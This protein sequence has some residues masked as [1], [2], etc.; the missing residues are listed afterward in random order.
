MWKAIVQ[1]ARA[2]VHL[3]RSVAMVFAMCLFVCVVCVTVAGSLIVV[4]VWL[5]PETV[6]LIRRIAG[7]KRHLVAM[8]TGQEIPQAY[9]PITGRL[10]QRLRTALRDPGTRSDLLWMAAFYLYGWMGLLTLALW[11]LGLVADGVWCGLLRRRPVVLPLISRLADL[12]AAWS[13]SLL[14]PFPQA[15]LAARVDELTQTRAGA[16][17]AHAAELRRIER[18]LHDGTQ[19]HLVSLSMR[20]G[21]ARRAY[22][23]APETARKL[24]DEA[25]EQAQ[26]ALAELRHVVRNIHPPILSDRGLAG[27]VRALA[28]GSGLDVTV[29]TDGLADDGPR[30]PA[31]VEAAA[32][33]AVAE[34][35]TNAAK[36]SG[37][38]RASVRLERTRTGLRVTVR[39]EG[40]GGADETSG[41]GL[42]GI[43]R[44]VAA[45]DG[46]VTVTSPE[47]GPT[48]VAV[49]LPCVW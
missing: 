23:S 8:W 10:R 33:F 16:V 45:L 15:L 9:Q 22:D 1:A 37:S 31:A 19:A 2:T 42:L 7:A 17:A 27:A 32:Y 20:L 5:I 38:S 40:E 12:E 30:A 13:A 47:G 49:E 44:R 41:S 28:A 43:R 3:G 24:L 46:T 48:V 34:A 21:L 18:D 6:L 4:G 25:Q 36:H 39:D 26:Q 14:K 11:P 29:D 35:L